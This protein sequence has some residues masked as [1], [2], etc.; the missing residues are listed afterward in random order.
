[1]AKQRA[2]GEMKLSPDGGAGLGGLLG[3]M[4]GGGQST[5]QGTGDVAG[6]LGGLLGMGGQRNPLDD[7]LGRL[8]R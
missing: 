7:I 1:M 8:G 4:L 5:G 2:G 6:A 3:G